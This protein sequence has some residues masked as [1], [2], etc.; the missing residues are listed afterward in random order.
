VPDVFVHVIAGQ[1]FNSLHVRA[2]TLVLP[3]A[4]LITYLGLRKVAARRS[5]NSL[6]ITMLA[7]VWLTGGLF[8]M[9]AATASGSGFAGAN[10]IRDSF[11]IIALS[12]IPLITYM[13]ATYDGSLFALL[14]VTVSVFLMLGI[15][16]SG[17]PLPF[18]RRSK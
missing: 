3:I 16:R 8:M 6:G 11:F 18:V 5:Y 12:L 1:Q 7:G 4:F 13:L 14:A 10:G 17:M 2:I 15:R 9:V